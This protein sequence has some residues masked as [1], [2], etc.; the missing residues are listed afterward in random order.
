MVCM[1][2]FQRHA[3]LADA[4]QYLIVAFN[5]LFY[6]RLSQSFTNWLW[7][8]HFTDVEFENTGFNLIKIT[9]KVNEGQQR[10][11]TRRSYCLA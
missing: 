10:M 9:Y 2:K 1:I 11:K 6:L 7:H 4:A 3:N 5:N 8:Y